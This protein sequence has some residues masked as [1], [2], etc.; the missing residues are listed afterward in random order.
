M[1]IALLIEDRD[2][3]YCFLDAKDAHG[4]ARV[5]TL[6]TKGVDFCEI[7]DENRTVWLQKDV[8]GLPEVLHVVRRDTINFDEADFDVVGYPIPT[9]ILVLD[10]AEYERRCDC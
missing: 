4:D 3:A 5:M 9:P 6:T 1:Q 8:D 7:E 2:L 10:K